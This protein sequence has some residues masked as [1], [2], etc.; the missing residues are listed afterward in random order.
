MF[1]VKPVLNLESFVTKS[2]KKLYLKF[3][4]QIILFQFTSFLRGHEKYA[5]H[6]AQFD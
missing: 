5:L 6:E 1:P 2:D 4:F 3:L